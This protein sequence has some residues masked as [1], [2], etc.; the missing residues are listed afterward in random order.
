MWKGLS[1]SNV[2]NSPRGS[3]CMERKGQGLFPP[4]PTIPQNSPPRLV[5]P[6]ALF[7]PPSTPPQPIG[8]GKGRGFPPPSPP[9]SPQPL[10]DC[11]PPR[12][13]HEVPIRQPCT[14]PLCL[15]PLGHFPAHPPIQYMTQKLPIL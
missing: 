10:E 7:I 14:M 6:V 12:R 5:G 3:V 8:R 1:I 2:G 11:S 15:W 4:A 13:C 9:T